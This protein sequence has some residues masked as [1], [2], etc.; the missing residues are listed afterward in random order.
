MFAVR[1]TAVVFEPFRTLNGFFMLAAEGRMRDGRP[2]VCDL[3]SPNT[4]LI[5]AIAQYM[6]GLGKGTAPMMRLIYK[7]RDDC[8]FAVWLREHPQDAAVLKRV[9][10]FLS[11]SLPRR[12]GHFQEFPI[13]LVRLV[14]TRVEDACKRHIV[15]EPACIASCGRLIILVSVIQAP[16]PCKSTRA[17][18]K[19]LSQVR[20]ACVAHVC[21]HC[22]LSVGRYDSG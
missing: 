14:D 5:T 3:A 7:R 22:H 16:L 15:Q 9:I 8:S 18:P 19:F 13:K 6:V 11:A 12:L 21:P 10:L 20:V 17:C 1:A 2:I 4:S